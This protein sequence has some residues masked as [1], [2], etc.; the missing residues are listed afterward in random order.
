VVEE[1]SYRPL[2]VAKIE[3]Q[4]AVRNL[5]E[6]IAEADAIMVAR[7][8]LG[9]ECP[10]EELPIIQRRTVKNCLKEGKPVIVATHM[11][12][13]MIDNPVPTRAEIT[14]VA[15]AVCEQSE[16]IRLS[17]ETTVG[18]YPLKCI[19]ILNRISTRIEKSGGAN[20]HQA[21]ELVTARQ[22]I[23][24]SAV[25]MANELKAEGLL[26][27]T[28]HGNLARYAAWM[29]P[30]SAAVFAVVQTEEL[31]RRL[32][33]NYGVYPLV[34]PFT[35][36]D[37]EEKITE[38][39]SKLVARKQLTKGNHLVIVSSILVEDQH[40]DTIQMRQVD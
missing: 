31:A 35:Q 8:D 32:A 33:I 4:E 7:G 1:A 6:I 26:I 18:K 40:V 21:A 12:E 16:A 11:L 15:N 39:I 38:A 28:L 22:K 34:L 30:Y 29:R 19:E 36:H 23:I 37:P 13:S 10:F 17:G 20:F 25:V 3:D 14:D 5:N 2:L 27:F 24:K 9:I